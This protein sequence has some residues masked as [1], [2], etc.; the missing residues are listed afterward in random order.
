MNKNRRV[1]YLLFKCIKVYKICGKYNGVCKLQWEYVNTMF[2]N[3]FSKENDKI[4]NFFSCVALIFF[5]TYFKGQTIRTLDIVITDTGI[6]TGH[7]AK[8][9]VYNSM[10]LINF[11][12]SEHK[13]NGSIFLIKPKI[14]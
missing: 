4:L 9:C 8:L 6:F 7:N 10:I 5:A 2:I 1:V 14:L 11:T 12:S 3:I 13:I